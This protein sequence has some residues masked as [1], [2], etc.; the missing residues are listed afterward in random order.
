M[1]LMG[2]TVAIL[3]ED[4][5]EDQEL[6][7]PLLRFREAGAAVMVVGAEKGHTYLSKHG[8]PVTADAAAASMDPASIDALIIPGGYAPDLM[9]RHPGMIRLVR[10][11]NADGGVIAF[12]CH[13]GWVPIS[14]GIGTRL[15]SPSRTT[16]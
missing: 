7:Y 2:K 1:T 4:Q 10:A 16:W 13:G 6:W 9:R 3:A 11:V 15:S 14:A 5:Y 12:I 8:Y